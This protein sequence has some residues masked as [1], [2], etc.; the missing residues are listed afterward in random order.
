MHEFGPTNFRAKRANDLFKMLVPL[1]AAPRGPPGG[2]EEGRERHQHFEEI[3]RALRA[4]IFRSELLHI[5][6]Q[7]IVE[8]FESG[9]SKS[10]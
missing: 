1:P 5:G 7:L 10:G 2:P 4:Q 9:A 6:F 8:I 3:V